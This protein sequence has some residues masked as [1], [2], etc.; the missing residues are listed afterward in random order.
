MGCS[1]LVTRP[2]Q[3]MSDTNAAIRAAREVQANI[4]APD[5]FRQSNEWFFKARQ[6]YK[7]KNFDL[8]KTYA[9]RARYLAEQAEIDSISNG[10][11]RSEAYPEDKA[12]VSAPSPEPYPSP[13][14]TPAEVYEKRKADEDAERRAQ[15][16]KSESAP[17]P[18]TNTP[19]PTTIK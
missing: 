16:K 19:A 10:G 1:I 12:P 11:N 3:E 8:A 14:A 6:Q 15:E 2:V 9:R 4:Y 5:L 13:E 18:A 7:I 17:L